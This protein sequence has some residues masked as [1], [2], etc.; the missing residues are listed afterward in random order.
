[1][2]N[3]L[4]YKY[5]KL[6]IVK[7]NVFLDEANTTSGIIWVHISLNSQNVQIFDILHKTGNFVHFL[8]LDILGHM[9]YS[10]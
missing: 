2:L 7:K 4:K 6:K 3:M 9:T 10:P 1:M 5:C 8:P